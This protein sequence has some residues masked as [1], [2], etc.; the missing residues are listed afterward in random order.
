M[1]IC[2]RIYREWGFDG[3][4]CGVLQLWGLYTR[5]VAADF[6]I[7]AAL[8]AAV[9]LLTLKDRLLWGRIACI[10]FVLMLAG[11]AVLGLD[12]GCAD[13]CRGRTC[14]EYVYTFQDILEKLKSEITML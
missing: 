7:S 5:Q 13:Y 8:A 1:E 6:A 2:H 9:F 14:D 11:I 3:E 12:A 4:M 10:G